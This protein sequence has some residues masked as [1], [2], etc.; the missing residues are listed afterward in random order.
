MGDKKQATF[1]VRTDMFPTVKKETDKVIL[2]HE[3]VN[4]EGKLNEWR[5]ANSRFIVAD[6]RSL[7]KGKMAGVTEKDPITNANHKMISQEEKDAKT[8]KERLKAE[9]RRSST[10]L[11]MI[12][13]TEQAAMWGRA[14]ASARSGTA[15]RT[16][17][18]P[19]LLPAA[20][21]LTQKLTVLGCLVSPGTWGRRSARNR[22]S[23]RLG[24]RVESLLDGVEITDAERRHSGIGGHVTQSYE[25]L[26]SDFKFDIDDRVSF[27]ARNALPERKKNRGMSYDRLSCTGWGPLEFTRNGPVVKTE[28]RLPPAP[29]PPTRQL[30]QPGPPS[31]LRIRTDC[32]PWNLCRA[33]NSA[34]TERTARTACH[35]RWSHAATR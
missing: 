1:G 5:N 10:S 23:M 25:E 19:L 21:P 34:G 33:R 35:N 4:K 18:P 9:A 11:G 2:W 27:S 30:G 6:A 22:V 31:A 12:S 20:P 32:W 13:A 17:R 3:H 29:H 26:P 7:A 24:Q 15:T 28:V 8:L 14:Q 16:A